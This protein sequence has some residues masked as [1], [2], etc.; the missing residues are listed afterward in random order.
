MSVNYLLKW[1]QEFEIKYFVGPLAC[2]K[3][4][5]GKSWVVDWG[6]THTLNTH[7]SIHAKQHIQVKQCS[8]KQSKYKFKIE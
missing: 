5:Q 2:A 7:A 8:T 6:A 4:L 3:A 1:K